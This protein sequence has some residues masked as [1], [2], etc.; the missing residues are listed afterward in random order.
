MEN[1]ALTQRLR[2]LESD[3]AAAALQDA[4]R[5]EEQRSNGWVGFPDH[6]L[7]RRGKEGVRGDGMC[8]FVC[9][10]VCVCVCH[11]LPSAPSFPLSRALALLNPASPLPACFLIRPSLPVALRSPSPFPPFP[12]SFAILLVYV[13]M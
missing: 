2:T 7:R 3:G 10:C 1:A 9:V 6:E 4:W 5:E 13:R 11:I 8:V 12:P